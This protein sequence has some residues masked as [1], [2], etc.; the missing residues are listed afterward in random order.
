MTHTPLAYG[1]LGNDADQWG[2]YELDSS[3]TVGLSYHGEEYARI[4]AAAPELLEALSW[5]AACLEN[6]GPHMDSQAAAEKARE[7]IR[8]ATEG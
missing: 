1:K 7:A 8:K 4:F 2:I 5:C 6:P 3:R